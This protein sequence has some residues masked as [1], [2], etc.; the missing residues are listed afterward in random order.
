ME[1]RHVWWDFFVRWLKSAGL[2]SAMILFI[3]GQG[4]LVQAA[5]E[6]YA[7]PEA[8]AMCHEELATNF[9]KTV[10]GQKA[11]SRTPAA[12]H[13]CETCHGPLAAH[14]NSGGDKGTVRRLGKD[15]NLSVSEI[16]A[17]CMECHQ[18]GKEALWDS[19]THAAKG[20]TCTTCHSIHGGHD[21]FL[22]KDVARDVCFQCHGTI[23]AQL[24]RTSH[25][26]I[27]E[28]KIT[29]TNCHNPHGS[30]APHQISANTINEKCYECHAEKRGPFLFEHRPVVEDCTIC[31]TPHGSSYGKLLVKKVPYL[32][33]SCHSNSR[34][35]G[36]L[37][38]RDAAN[39]GTNTYLSSK[40]SNRPLYRACLNC[41][42]NIHGSNHPSGKTFTR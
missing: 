34:H 42:T 7:G 33:Q 26:P 3:L 5:D 32:C 25:H 23:R 27:R 12:K 9:A 15:T 18:K 13:A 11:D 38:A 17:T 37:Y 29:C 10:H 28:G 41:H 14:V 35:P 40:M 39:P 31:H 21:K 1:K 6:G 8:C 2:F 22:V 20:L 4:G 36:T 16:N 30:V 19:S 24:Q